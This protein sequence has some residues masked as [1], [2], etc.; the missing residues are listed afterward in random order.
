MNKVYRKH[1]KDEKRI[2]KLM[3]KKGII[4]SLGFNL[5]NLGWEYFLP[6]K[7]T[8]KRKGDRKWTFSE[9]LPQLHEYTV[10]YWGEGDSYSIVEYYKQCVHYEISEVDEDSLFPTGKYPSNSFMIKHLRGMRTVKNDSRFNRF[11]KVTKE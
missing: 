3:Y 8:R 7:R 11:L 2:L 4:D 9:Y 10:D 5:D 6:Y 1:L